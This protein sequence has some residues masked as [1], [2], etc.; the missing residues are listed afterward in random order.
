MRG[1]TFLS[2]APAAAPDEPVTGSTAAGPA[3]GLS[4]I[5]ENTKGA[6]KPGS[7][8]WVLTLGVFYFIYYYLY[9]KKW[10][11]AVSTDALLSFMH[12]AASVT[13]LAVVGINLANVFFTKLAAMRIPVLS[14]AAGAALPLFHL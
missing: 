10:K 4:N 1:D 6:N 13:I 11:E 12:L 8:V 7:I 9:N 3:A 5:E 2:S 14:R